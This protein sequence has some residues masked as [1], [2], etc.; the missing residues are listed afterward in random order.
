MKTIIKYYRYY[1]AFFF[2]I[3]LLMGLALPANSV[4]AKSKKANVT[5]MASK[6]EMSYPLN[7]N[8]ADAEKLSMI[9]GIGKSRAEAIVSY[10]DENGMFKTAESLA[11]VRG[12]SVSFIDK[13]RE[14]ITVK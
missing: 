2:C 1:V 8:T 3:F 12:I 5:E 14:Y 13:H 11:E 6:Q 10:R 4:Y 9:P 7:I